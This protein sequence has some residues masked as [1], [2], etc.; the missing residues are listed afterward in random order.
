[1]ISKRIKDLLGIKKE[2]LEVYTIRRFMFNNQYI[3]NKLHFFSDWICEYTE[4]KNS[5]GC[6]SAV[7]DYLKQ[8]DN[9]KKESKTRGGNL[10]LVP[11]YFALWTFNSLPFTVVVFIAC[12]TSGPFP[13]SISTKVSFS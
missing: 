1:M 4:R 10:P 7:S 3:Q 13:F 11:L 8:I 12:N 6:K 5:R 9:D 2:R